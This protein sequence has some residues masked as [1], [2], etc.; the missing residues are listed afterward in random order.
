MAEAIEEIEAVEAV[1]SGLGRLRPA[2]SSPRHPKGLEKGAPGLPR[3]QPVAVVDLVEPDGVLWSTCSCSGL[4]DRPLFADLLGEVADRT[5]RPIQI[6]EQRG[7]AA[8]HPVSASC[9]ESDYLKCFLCRV[10]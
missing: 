5:G 6:L 2:P 10:G 8:D 4:V 3:S 9:L 1:G 7:Q